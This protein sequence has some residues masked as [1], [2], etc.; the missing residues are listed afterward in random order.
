MNTSSLQG[1][2][3]LLAVKEKANR[4]HEQLRL[5]YGS[6]DKVAEPLQDAWRMLA[7]SIEDFRAWQEGEPD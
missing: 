5:L 7:W 4:L 1:T 6:P 3:L 2:V